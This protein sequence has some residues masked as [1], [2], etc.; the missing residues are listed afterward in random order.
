MFIL[1][2]QDSRL[3]VFR[4]VST[5]GHKGE[6]LA[7]GA[8]LALRTMQESRECCLAMA[9]PSQG[10]KV[11]DAGLDSPMASYLILRVTGQDGRALARNVPVAKMQRRTT[12]RPKTL[13]KCE[14]LF[15]SEG[16]RQTLRLPQTKDG[17]FARF[18]DMCD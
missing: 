17:C 1:D 13:P 8:M 4:R 15:F 2:S 12:D 16:Q 11:F 3:M 10:A 18:P 14:P 7:Q 5:I 6:I 9:V